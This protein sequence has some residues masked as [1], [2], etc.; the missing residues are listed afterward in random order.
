MYGGQYAVQGNEVTMN[1]TNHRIHIPI[2]LGGTTLPVFHYENQKRAIGS[3]LRLFLA[4][5]RLSKLDLFGDIKYI[6][7]LQ[8][9]DISSNK[10]K[11]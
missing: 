7:Y 8:A 11:I 5:S 10:M 6:R 3:K 1:L 4:Y 2:G 9:M